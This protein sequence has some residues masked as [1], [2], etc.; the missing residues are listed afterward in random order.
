MKKAFKMILLIVKET[1]QGYIIN[2][3][4][5]LAAG[6][7]FYTIFSLTPLLGIA[8]GVAGLIFSETVVTEKLMEETSRFVSPQVAQ[9]LM[10]ALENNHLARQSVIATAFSAL[11]MLLAASFMFSSLKMSIDLMWGIA[12]PPNQGLLHILRTQ[13]LS[14][15]MVL[16]TGLLLLVFMVISTLIISLNQWLVFLPI[17]AQ[18]LLPRADFGL[19]F[20]GFGLIFAIIFKILPDAEV[21]W[22]D[23][24]LGAAVTAVAFTIGS[25]IIGFYLGNYAFSSSFGIASSLFIIL[26]WIYYSMQ[27]ILLGAKFT[28]V[29]ANHFGK[30]VRPRKKAVWVIQEWK[31]PEE[32]G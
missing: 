23:I 32:H 1:Y 27:I 26:L 15:G 17:Q 28:Q 21:H 10:T 2:H 12:H 24:W 30:R 31:A 9:T 14:F 13:F 5:L 16:I 20:I 25:F 3:G 6:L 8:V 4:V 22:S 19:M 11:I 18:D 29:Y 7:A